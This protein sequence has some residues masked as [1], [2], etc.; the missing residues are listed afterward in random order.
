MCHADLTIG[1]VADELVRAVEEDRLSLRVIDVVMNAADAERLVHHLVNLII[2]LT[3]RCGRDDLRY[4]AE[5]LWVELLTWAITAREDDRAL[6]EPAEEG[7]VQRD[8]AGALYTV[9][10]GHIKR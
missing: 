4:R 2:A 7:A 10:D 1:A 6:A 5:Q 3:L 8:Q 9:K